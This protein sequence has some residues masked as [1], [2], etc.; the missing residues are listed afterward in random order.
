VRGTRSDGCACPGCPQGRVA[1]LAD[2]GSS[3]NEL[4]WAVRARLEE[5][6]LERSL[7]V[8]FDD[9]QWGEPTFL[10]LLDHVADLSRGAPIFL[11]CLARP[12]LLDRRPGWGGGKLNTTTMLLEPLSRA[13]CEELIESHGNLIGVETRTRILEA[14]DGN[15]LFVEEMLALA[16]ESGDVRVPSTIQAL[17]QARLDQL[18]RGERS[19]IER[20]AVEGQVFHR[21]AVR[22]LSPGAD[23]EPELVGLVRKEMIR[24]EPSTFA[25]DHAF[26]FRH[27]LIRDAA[28]DALPKGTRAELHERFAVWLASHG[29]GLIELDEIL[30]HHFEQAARY[31][32]ELGHPDGSLERQAALH[33]AAAGAK[34]AARSDLP[35]ADNLLGRALAFLAADD[36][37]RLAVVLER[38]VA[39]EETGKSIERMNLIAELESYEDPAARMHG[40]MARLLHRIRSEPHSVIDE[41]RGASEEA[42]VVFAAAGDELGIARVWFLLFWVDWLQSRAS[43][44]LA[45]LEHAIE[46]AELAGAHALAASASVYLLGPLLYG[47]FTPGEVRAR[48]EPLRE[49]GGALATNTVLRVEAKVLTGEGRFEEAFELHER[50]DAIVS[51]L[52]MTMTL[53]VMRQWPA[54]LMLLQGR[55]RESVV[56]MRE[57]VAGL[58]ELGETS[59]RS[60]ALIRLGEALYRCG[61]GEEAEQRA[62]EGEKLGAEEDIV[63]YA[64]GRGLRAQIVADRG[65][66]DEADALAREALEYAY[67]TDFPWVQALTH[68][69]LAKTLTA[70]GRTEEAH[71]ELKHAIERFESYGNGFEAEQTRLLMQEL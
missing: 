11:L 61:E 63:N 29:E 59:F 9:I 60:T 36:P 57:L 66:H 71:A 27:L 70:A 47:P 33:L 51:D 50:A 52:G 2:G 25:G 55:A 13:E 23:I 41:A 44:A 24:P 37:R 53:V 21:A 34:A 1:Q 31:G 22:E 12:D 26:R 40:R 3:Q 43:P 35:A 39:L 69:D 28:Y 15:P 68:K 54:E 48:L 58:E 19:V 64:R 67:Q 32:R 7:V 16:H 18:G 14:A 6:A 42:L 8:V 46:H 56:L 17:L 5:T 49:A 4:F 30:G 62:I 45:S 20:G 65:A 38:V 10:D